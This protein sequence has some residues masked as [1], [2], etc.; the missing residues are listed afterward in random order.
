MFQFLVISFVYDKYRVD[1]FYFKKPNI[2]RDILFRINKF[3]TKCFVFAGFHSPDCSG[4]FEVKKGSFSWQKRAT[5]G[6]PFLHKK[7]LFLRGLEAESR[8]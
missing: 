5:Q 8:E 7:Q 1:E 3:Y 4:K 6:A 2:I